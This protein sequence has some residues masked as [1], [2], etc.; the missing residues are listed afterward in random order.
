M[1]AE[2]YLGCRRHGLPCSRCGTPPVLWAPWRDRPL[3]DR[4]K[5]STATREHAAQDGATRMQRKMVQ[6]LPLDIKAV[7]PED[8]GALELVWYIYR[9]LL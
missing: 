3:C 9:K 1:H 4:R 6:S 8:N 7:L 2:E 5:W